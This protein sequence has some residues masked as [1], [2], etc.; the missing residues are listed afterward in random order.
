MH[1]VISTQVVQRELGE[2]SAKSGGGAPI[3]AAL[4]RLGGETT[5]S[6]T[7]AQRVELLKAVIALTVDD[8]SAALEAERRGVVR[9]TLGLVDDPSADEPTTMLALRGE[10][11]RSSS[12]FCSVSRASWRTASVQLLG[13]A[14]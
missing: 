7:P 1:H 13:A 2:R 5:E 9:M 8:P 6:V 3:A 12:F 14:V 4:A 10:S 11:R